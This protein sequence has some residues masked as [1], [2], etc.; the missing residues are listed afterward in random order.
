MERKRLVELGFKEL[1]HPT[2]GNVLIYDLGKRRHLSLGSLSTPNEL[3]YLCERSLNNEKIITDLIC[4]H[5][6]DYNGYLSESKLN[7]LLSFFINQ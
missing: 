5:N 3:L 7:L 4:I 1:P 2:I 6:Y